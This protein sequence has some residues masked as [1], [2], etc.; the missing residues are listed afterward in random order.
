MESSWII[1]VM[2]VLYIVA[3]ALVSF[4]V[5][6]AGRTSEGFIRGGKTFPAIIIGLFLASEVIG[7]SA[8]IGTA[9]GA[10]KGGISAA[11]NIGALGLGFILFA[12]FL[13]RKFKALDELT[14]SG[15]LERTYGGKVRRATSITMI[16]SL[17]LVAT[18]AYKSGGAM[19][20]ELF[21]VSPEWA[22]VIVGSLASVYVGIGG[23]KSVIYT[24]IINIVVK[25]VSIVI[26]A[27]FAYN[28]AGGVEGMRI[29]LP[30]KMLSW[31]GVGW[32]QIGAWLIAGGGAMFSTQYV[33][34]SITAV[35]SE[36]KARRASFY[37]SLILIPY[38]FLA[39]LIGV[40]A[41]V[42]HPDIN[43]LNAL[44]VMVLDLNPFLAGLAVTGLTASVFG[45]ISAL[46][47]GASTLLLKDFYQPYFNK[48]NHEGK[49]IRF[50]RIATVVCGLIPV[51]LA[52]F[53]ANV[54]E[55]TFLAKA[56]RASLAVFVVLMFYKPLFGT[57]QGAIVSIWCSLI[58]TIG[59]YLLGN[60]FGVDNAYI[61][62]ATPIIV[63]AVFHIFR[64]GDKPAAPLQ[65]S[66]RPVPAPAVV[67]TAER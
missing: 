11:W 45:L 28:A 41:A 20:S 35:D 34:Q 43:S 44:P 4:L 3:L 29:A 61:A 49:S 16:A 17:L 62:I 59:W 66:A 7:T 52:L 13:A 18:A 67:A 57:K 6:K 2:V 25:V 1:T 27:A 63:M 38:G 53:A 60:P 5:R 19:L 56:L 32:A 55:V 10:F 51:A 21:H 65:E 22:V 33:I 64:L 8:S 31:D 54:L 42:V 15:A 46:T 24:N 36:T 26:V 50:A 14:I 48:K 58:T 39:A 40:S 9:Q 30:A 37:T 23:M 12:I 47:I